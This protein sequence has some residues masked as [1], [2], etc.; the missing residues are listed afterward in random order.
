VQFGNVTPHLLRTATGS[1]E[2]P[3][4]LLTMRRFA[5]ASVRLREREAMSAICHVDLATFCGR[6][7]NLYGTYRMSP[8]FSLYHAAQGWIARDIPLSHCVEV[9]E[10]FLR[11]HAGNCYS[12]SGDWNFAWL[13]SLIQTTWHDRSFATLP[14]SA[15]QRK[16]RQDW[17]DEYGAEGSSRRP[18]RAAAFNAGPATVNSKPDS[19]EL[20]RIAPWKKVARAFSPA[21][22]TKSGFPQQVPKP[23]RSAL[24]FSGQ[25]PASGPKKIDVAVA[26]LRA[27]LVGGERAAA[28][29]ESNALCAGIAPRTYDRARKRLGVTSRRIGFGRLARYAIALPGV[30]GA[31]SKGANL[32]GA[33]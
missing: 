13:N 28:E 26:W 2:Q 20:D 3:Y 16:R 29:V 8:P 21:R 18:G 11:R 17:P 23:H 22:D 12:G 19:F 1:T 24:R 33:T 15:P 5:I 6:I 25:T 30:H 32:A 31:P 4:I 10:D 9:I 7:G 27:E 14:S